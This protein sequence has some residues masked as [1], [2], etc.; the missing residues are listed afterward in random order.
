M[1]KGAVLKNVNLPYW[2]LS[3]FYFFY[4]AVL[5]V[6]VPYWGLYLQDMGFSALEIGYLS[7]VIMATKIFAPSIWGWIADRTGRRLQIVRGGSLL[8]FVVCFGMFGETRFLWLALVVF[9]YTFFWNAVL[10]QFEV[11]TLRHLGDRPEWYS[12][13]RLW[14]SVGFIVLVVILGVVFDHISVSWLPWFLVLTLGAI[15][16]CSLSVPEAPV[17]HEHHEETEGLWDILRKPVVVV[18]L[19]CN[20]LLQIAHGP[21]Y[22]FYSI[23][24]EEHGYNRQWIGWLWALGVLAE[25]AF[26]WVM[27]QLLPRYGLRL[28]ILVSLALATV[29]W[30]MIGFGVESLAVL[31]IAQLLHAFTFGVLHSV[32]IEAIRRFFGHAHQGQGQALYSGLSFGAGGAVGA[33]VSGQLWGSWGAAW[34]FSLAS[35]ACFIAFLLAAYFLR[36]KFDPLID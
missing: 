21:Y 19:L 36:S 4:F 18:F 28:L 7:A 20:F 24:L 29:R 32:S 30:F 12:R 5:G 22:T 2:R 9:L 15:W 11:I 8:A 35:L 34:V 13:V 10:A 14:G 23:F 17:A 26:F 25:V 1:L 6:L 3:G 27:H 31:V 16:L 33:A